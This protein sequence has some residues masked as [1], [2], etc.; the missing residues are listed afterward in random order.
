MTN[1]IKGQPPLPPQ[2]SQP[3][4]EAKPKKGPEE[5]SNSMLKNA[6]TLKQMHTKGRFILGAGEPASYDKDLKNSDQAK[7]AAKVFN[8]AIGS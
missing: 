5:G 6:D 3:V 7:L 2:H 8:R 1:P 4:S